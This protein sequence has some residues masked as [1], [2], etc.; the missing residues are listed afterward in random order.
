MKN[1]FFNF[2][3][4]LFLCIVVFSCKKESTA[5]AIPVISSV[6]PDSG[7]A[8]TLVTLRGTDLMDVRK[9]MFEKDSV[10]ASFNPVFNTNDVLLFRVPDTASGGDQ[11]IYVI[12]SNGNKI[13][14]PF[15]V[16][17]L[18]VIADVSNYNFVSGDE[19]VLMGNNLEDVKSVT[20][21]D[22]VNITIVSKGKKQLVLQMPDLTVGRAKLIITNSSGVSTT[23]Q[24]FVNLKNTYQ[25][26]TDAY[27]N[28]V[29]NA[30]WGPA[31][32]STSIAKTGSAS[33]AATYNQGNWSADGFA[34]W[35]TGIPDLTKQ[36]YT[37]L[38]FWIMGGT[39][40]HTLYLTGS[41]RP[42]GYGNSDQTTPLNVKAG[43]WNYYKLPLASLNLW[44]NGNSFQQLGWWIK[45]PNDSNETFYFDDVVFV[46]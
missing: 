5:T 45:G 20:T 23:T 6:A 30:S 24:E 36:G 34:N 13:A 3:L 31:Q 44:S 14:F 37:Y 42:A 32:I 9:I 33:F 43:V 35:G 2:A 19:I 38:T 40:D 46:K 16:I 26:F 22:N 15:K 8:G 21:Q 28:G 41:G 29:E 17:A 1:V 4:F 12:K 27:N 11:N 10:Y 18:P 7:S 25:L 39:T